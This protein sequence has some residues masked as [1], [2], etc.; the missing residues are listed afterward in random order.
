MY[1]EHSDPTKCT[2]WTQNSDV[3]DLSS[4]FYTRAHKERSVPKV[5]AFWRNLEESN[6]FK[7]LEGGLVSRSQHSEKKDHLQPLGAGLT[8]RYGLPKA[9][10]E[11]SFKNVA[12]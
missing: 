1:S 5:F 12:S 3:L 2:R 9:G 11:G 4:I 6:A 10:S 7:Q 8:S